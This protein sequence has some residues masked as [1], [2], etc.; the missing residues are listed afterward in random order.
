[1][2]QIFWI[3]LVFIAFFLG[4]K[5]SPQK[6]EDG[7]SKKPNII[8][9][10]SDDQSY[11]T[12]NALGN[13]EI[14]TPTM[15]K[16]VNEGVTFTHSYNMGGWNGA[17]CLAS[18][19]MIISGR[20]VWR[21]QQISGNYSKN[22]DL[23][24]TWPRLMQT[25]GY[26]TYMTGKWHVNAK[27]DSIFNHVGHVLRGMPFD[28]PEGY[29]RPQSEN[30]TLWKPWKKEFG[31]Y[32][33]GGKHW[34][35]LVKDDA[36]SFLGEAAEKDKPF[37]MYIAFNAPHD[38]RQS[39]KEYVDMYPLDKVSIP[40][41]FIPEYPY[42]ESMGA[43]KKLRDEKLAPF[44]RTEYSVKVNRQEYYAI[45]SHLDDQI[46][47]ILNELDKKGLKENTYIFYGSDHGLA[48]GEHGLMG[49]QNMFDHSMRVPLMVVGPNIPKG[50]TIEAD[51]YVQDIM[52]SALEL[53]GVTK[54]D[55]VE[56]N[57]LIGLAKGDEKDQSKL[58]S[59]YGAYEKGS[60][61]MIRKDG[62]KLILYPRSKTVLLY[63]LEEDPNEL[64]N[65]SEDS[66]HKEKI[67]KLFKDLVDL[68]K[69]M[70]DKLDLNAVFTNLKTDS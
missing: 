31:G 4:C 60:Q 48:C 44:P 6:A 15:D 65:L 53:A 1:M 64:N 9:L 34:S 38:P 61:R 30:D 67:K 63:N 36:V 47:D 39:P 58:K 7:I 23:D 18:R 26:E 2:K 70:G 42:A 69:G 25:A 51:V 66:N 22:E 46:K 21:A 55:Y 27:P 62:Y 57:S 40:E 8:F 56:F 68:Q 45:T 28:T 59:I 37:F 35:E 24:K 33:K 13:K 14:I 5:E 32:W 19:A 50:K 54:P 12:V 10:F 16:L 20:S 3:A 41:S 49:K 29:N 17:I 52:A 11:K 43:G